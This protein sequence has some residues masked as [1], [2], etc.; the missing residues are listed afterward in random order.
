VYDADASCPLDTTIQNPALEV[1]VSGTTR[2]PFGTGTMENLRIDKSQSRSGY[3][4]FHKMV[5]FGR[6]MFVQILL[7]GY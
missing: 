7:A 4:L 6:H 5:T 3:T 2:V 1:G